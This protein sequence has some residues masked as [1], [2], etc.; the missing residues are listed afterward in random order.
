MIR[1]L[2]KFF[3]LF[4]C[5]ILSMHQ[6]ISGAYKLLSRLNSRALIVSPLAARMPKIMAN[7]MMYSHRLATVGVSKKSLASQALT[8]KNEGLV[9]VPSMKTD[10]MQQSHQ[11]SNGNSSRH[12]WYKRKYGSPLLGSGI[13]LSLLDDDKKDNTEPENQKAKDACPQQP[14]LLNRKNVLEFGVQNKNEYIASAIQNLASHDQEVIEAII[15]IIQ[16]WPNDLAALKKEAIKLYGKIDNKVIVALEK[17]DIEFKLLYDA[18]LYKKADEQESDA[19]ES[20]PFEKYLFDPIAFSLPTDIAMNAFK[21]CKNIGMEKAM[22]EFFKDPQNIILDGIW[23]T[24]YEYVR[25]I[26]DT[27]IKTA[28]NIQL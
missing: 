9:H 11:K 10:S 1:F 22:E 28:A 19:D 2:S 26:P 27:L 17:T 23:D 12:A 8:A 14:I 4:C 13:A 3:F 7:V 24:A 21:V 6:N 25:T 20:H 15:A 16:T 5:L 18:Q